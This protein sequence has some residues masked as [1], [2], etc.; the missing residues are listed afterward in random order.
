MVNLA[1]R[2]LSERSSALVA[3]SLAAER[4]FPGGADV[5]F[6][7]FRKVCSVILDAGRCFLRLA[8]IHF[9]AS[10]GLGHRGAQG[11]AMQATV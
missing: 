2:I 3:L 6:E 9:H 5:L 1:E 4:L 8:R 11:K 7:L 10:L